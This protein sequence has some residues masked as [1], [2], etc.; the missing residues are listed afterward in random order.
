MD[1]VPSNQGGQKGG[2][3]DVSFSVSI[4]PGVGRVVSIAQHYETDVKVQPVFANRGGVADTQDRKR[5]GASDAETFPGQCS[6]YPVNLGPSF[7]FMEVF[8]PVSGKI[9]FS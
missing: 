9:L 4:Y 5:T 1:F 8:Q 6:D 3:R 2:S 7:R